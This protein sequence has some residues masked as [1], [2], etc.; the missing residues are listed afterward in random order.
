MN[1]WDRGEDTGMEGDD[2]TV[3]RTEIC[4]G[5]SSWGKEIDRQQ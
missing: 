1:H 5:T 4:S 3:E 2:R